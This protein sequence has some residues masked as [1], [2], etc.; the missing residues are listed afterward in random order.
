MRTGWRWLIAMGVAVGLSACVDDTQTEAQ[1]TET[2]N[3]AQQTGNSAPLVSGIPSSWASAGAAWSFQIN[4]SD[5]D[6]DALTYTAT[7]LPAWVSIDTRTGL[8]GGTPSATDAGVT[9][10]IFISVS[11]GHTSTTL[12]SFRIT[13]QSAEPGVTEPVTPPAIPV[14]PPGASTPA[15]EPAPANTAPAIAGSPG[16][17]VVAGTNYSFTPAAS[18]AETSSLKFSVANKPAWA[19]FS[20]AT[21]TLTGQPTSSQSGTYSNIVIT[22]SDGA[23][24]ASLPAFSVTVTAPNGAPTISGTPITSAAS[25]KAY[26]FRPLATDPEGDA[27]AFSVSGKPS[28]ATFSTATG[29]LNGIT[30]AGTFANIVI[31]VSDGKT[32]RSL[33]AFT[34]AVNAANSGQAALSWSAPTQNSDGSALTDLAGYRVHHGTSADKFDEVIEIDGSTNTSYTFTQLPSGTHYFAVASFNSAGTESELSAVGSKT[35]Q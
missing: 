24:S 31:S 14:T 21:G 22:V 12:P 25:G 20:T 9:A 5:A 19:A 8:L 34:I 16:T 32:T 3:A 2:P 23:L 4:A 30:Q 13:I 33:P 11:D 35:I 6:G 15:P 28:W 26:T 29:A 27:L 1:S 10:D 7:G 18:D 17:A